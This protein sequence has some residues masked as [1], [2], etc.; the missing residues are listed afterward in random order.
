MSAANWGALGGEQQRL[1]PRD[2]I[3]VLVEKDVANRLARGTTAWLAD[4]DNLMAVGLEPGAQGELNRRL[5]GPFNAFEGYVVAHRSPAVG[6]ALLMILTP[7]L[8]SH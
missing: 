3:E 5:P 6:A 7:P 2:H 1:G 4:V 8:A